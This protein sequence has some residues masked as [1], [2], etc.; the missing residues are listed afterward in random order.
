M[1]IQE[2]CTQYAAERRG[3][4]SEKWDGLR[5]HFGDADLLAMWVADME[6]KAPKAVTRALAKRVEHGVFGYTTLPKGYNGAV[7]AWQQ[8]RHGCTIDPAW[9]RH[10]CGVVTALFYL[11][12]AF[13][14]PGDAICIQTPVYG[15]FASA[16]QET[17]RTLVEV[18][19]QSEGG[20]RMDFA[21]LEEAF[22]TRGVKMLIHSSP[23][24]PVGRVWRHDELEQLFSLCKRYHVLVLADEIHQDLIVG[25]LPQ[26]PAF[27]VGGGAYNSL[28]LCVTSASKTFNLAGLIHS[29]VMIADEGLR[30]T[31]DAYAAT[32]N[33]TATNLMG[34]VATQA[35]YEEGAEW[36]DALLDV[37]RHNYTLLNDAFAEALPKAVVSELEGTYLLW[38]D[39]RPYFGANDDAARD[40][41]Q[42]KCRL[43]VNNG[44]WFGE[45]FKGFVRFNLGT[46]PTIVEE[47]AAN[48]RREAAKL[49]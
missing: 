31:Y 36:L 37:I 45:Q 17:G 43:A 8:T 16:V 6:F 24:N 48:I 40:F 28:L 42:G 23:H 27:N 29:H 2:F 5:E 20:W 41:I 39:L 12:N 22:K 13:T 26:V 11:V 35:A 14:N 21:A 4:N 44:G 38:V 47:A 30:K 19:L 33:H 34:C 18:P 32:V 3:T 9:I 7:V 10:S 1:T 46:T 49:P 15:P 25:P